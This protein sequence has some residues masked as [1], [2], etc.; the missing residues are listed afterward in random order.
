M[1]V[2]ICGITRAADAEAGAAAGADWIGVNFWPRSKR[3]VNLERAAEVIDAARGARPDIV[4]V[5]LFVN[6]RIDG[7]CQIADR[8]ELDYVQ[9]HGDESADDCRSVGHRAIKAVPLQ[10][11]DDV[12]EMAVYPCEVMVVDTPSAGYGGSGET[13][14]WDLARLATTTGKKIVLAGGLGPDN[15]AAAIEAVAPFG[16]DVASGVESEPGIKDIERVR[17]FVEA[18]KGAA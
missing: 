7:V 14:D 1:I 6:Q 2:K 8:F 15:V 10:S 12:A 3:F 17:R 9:L 5:G 18:A 16:V 11:A 13:F 4:V